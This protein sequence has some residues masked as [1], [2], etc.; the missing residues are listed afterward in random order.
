MLKAEG[1]RLKVEGSKT[2]WLMAE[3]WSFEKLK[4]GT[5][6][7]GM[8]VLI[9]EVAVSLELR[10]G[11]ES[12]VLAIHL[13]VDG[14]DPVISWCLESG[15]SESQAGGI[16]CSLNVVWLGGNLRILV[17][18]MQS[19]LSVL[20]KSVWLTTFNFCDLNVLGI[21]MLVLG[22][23]GISALFCNDLLFRWPNINERTR[24]PV[25]I[26]FFFC[27]W[28]SEVLIK[29]NLFFLGNEL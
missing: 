16:G 15:L 12:L 5:L 20:V 21:W 24:I 3:S 8:F 23:R 11:G 28:F 17:S 2:G 7:S 26:L 22:S 19:F 6:K 4:V 29:S 14:L 25:A 18:S 9:S 1:W 10:Q 27:E 13:C